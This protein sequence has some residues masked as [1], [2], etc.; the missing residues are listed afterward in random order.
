M[1]HGTLVIAMSPA[2]LRQPMWIPQP[3]QLLR[4]AKVIYPYW[5]LWGMADMTSCHAVRSM[6]AMPHILATDNVDT[7]T[8]TTPALGKVIY[9]YW[10]SWGMADMTSCHAVR[11]MPAMPHGT[12]VIAM[13]PASL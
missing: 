13:S 11:S 8:C 4:L 6:P 3:A 7:T 12:L 2:S 10:L 5:L 1:P 9:P